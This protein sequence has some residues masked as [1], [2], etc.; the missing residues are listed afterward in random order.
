MPHLIK[1]ITLSLDTSAYADGDVLAETQLCSGVVEDVHG[2]AMVLSL[3]V[4]DK[5][6]QGQPLDIVFLK[7]NKGIGTENAQVSVSDA[8]ADEILGIVSVAAAD[9][10][11]LI[12]SQ[13][14]QITNVGILLE[15]APGS[16]DVYIAAISRGTGTYSASGITLK[17][18]LVTL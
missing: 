9:Y 11:D 3:G 8:D 4:L 6:D 16:V 14:A 2:K 15:S 1:P 18:G 12:N 7:S 17:I 5:D 10:K 13:Y